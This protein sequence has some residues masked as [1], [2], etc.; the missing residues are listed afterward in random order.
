VTGPVTIT[1]NHCT[2]SIGPN[3]VVGKITTTPNP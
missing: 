2:I 1:H 3:K